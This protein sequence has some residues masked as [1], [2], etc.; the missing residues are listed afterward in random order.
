MKSVEVADRYAEALYELGSEEGKLD[1]LQ[2]DLAE[3]A[4]LVDSNDQLMDFLI[5]PLVPNEDKESML[6]EILGESVLRETLNFLKLLVNKD[7]EDYLPLIYERLRVIR[8][9][10]E[11][12]IEVEITVPPDLDGGEIA[13]EV[14]GRLEEIM[15][16]SVFV[17]QIREDAGLI[18]GI[19][20]KVGE[21]IIDGSVQGEIRGLRE[22][23]LEGGSNGRN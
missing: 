10:E 15:E 8:R 19:R 5:H 20:L 23:I 2:G 3:V 11:E 14:K 4:R 17:T 1:Q 16:K 13:E 9:D 6:D 22:H 12:I 18:G 21:H 7:R